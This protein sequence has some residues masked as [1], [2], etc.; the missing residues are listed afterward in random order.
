M[1]TKSSDRPAHVGTFDE[2]V[3]WARDNLSPTQWRSFAKQLGLKEEKHFYI[4]VTFEYE[5]EVERHLV[6]AESLR[7]YVTHDVSQFE[8]AK[9]VE[10]AVATRDEF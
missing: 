8:Y 3:A 9:N 10:V 5:P 2:A 7:R 4:S 6:D 1:Q